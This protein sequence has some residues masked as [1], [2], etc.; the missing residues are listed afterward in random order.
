MDVSR[1]VFE[2]QCK[3]RF[4][5][6]NPE[7]FKMDYW[8]WM[9]RCGRE[10]YSVRKDLGLEPNWFAR[11]KDDEGRQPNPDWC[12]KRY[13]M[14]RTTMPDGRVICIAGEHEDSYDPDFCIYN[15][16]VVLRPAHGQSVISLES[17]GVEIYGYPDCVFPPT[18][19]HSATMINK[20]IFVIGRLGYHGTRVPRLTP[21][22]MLD[23]TTYEMK[24]IETTGPYP[25]W[26]YKHHASYDP[27][28]DSITVRGGFIEVRDF[29]RETPYSA[30]HRLNLA[31]M[32]WEIVSTHE[33]H[34]WFIFEAV[35]PTPDDFC[36]AEETSFRPQNVPYTW[37]MSEERGAPVYSIDIRG[38]RVTFY[39]FYTEIRAL[40][41]GDLPYQVV[42]QLL[43]DIQMNLREYTKADW[44][45][46]ELQSFEH[47]W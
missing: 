46:R 45:F 24:S 30:A 21:V 29:E 37:L 11:S 7:Q 32:R 28:S 31:D 19:F 5:T 26:I 36:E 38:V 41:E 9:V 47:Q 42:E 25:G 35:D 44:R 18:D 15:D 10:P 1:E 14:S 39:D 23:T 40:V 3:H 20:A 22:F 34:R 33:Q 27:A 12:F 6:K 4:G 16:V 2:Q 17:G 13:G 8:E 43:A